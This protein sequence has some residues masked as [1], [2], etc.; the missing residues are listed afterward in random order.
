M[1]KRLGPWEPAHY[2]AADASAIQALLRGDADEH[3]QQRA[4]KWII[5]VAAATYDQS[6][7]PGGEDGKR[8]TDFA[9]GR[10]FVGN[11]V[12]KMLKLNV[13]AL[14]KEERDVQG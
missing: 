13:Q 11:S 7:W 5:E 14:L 12:V 9:E 6:F 4:L 3:Q 2:E 8:N 10:R 1:K